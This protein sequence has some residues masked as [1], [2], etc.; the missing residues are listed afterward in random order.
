MNEPTAGKPDDSV[1]QVFCSLNKN[2]PKCSSIGPIYEP[3]ELNLGL[4]HS[5]AKP[6]FH[7][8]RHVVFSNFMPI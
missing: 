2:K 1:S 7:S 8:H 3:F 6:G 5:S 4:N